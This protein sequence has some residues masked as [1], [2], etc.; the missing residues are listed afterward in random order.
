[1]LTKNLSEDSDETLSISLIIQILSIGT[2]FGYTVSQMSN[3]YLNGMSHDPNWTYYLYLILTTFFTF[4]RLVFTIGYDNVTIRQAAS[5]ASKM[6]IYLTMFMTLVCS[7][8]YLHGANLT[9]NLLEDDN[10]TDF[11]SLVHN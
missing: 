1:M 5:F 3:N 8:M 11:L 6:M 9:Y 7:F 4:F 2:M 10:A